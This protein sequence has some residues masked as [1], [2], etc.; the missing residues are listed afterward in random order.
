[1]KV[2]AER[3]DAIFYWGPPAIIIS[4]LYFYLRFGLGIRILPRYYFFVFFLTLL[5]STIYNLAHRLTLP[6]VLIE[7]DKAGIYIYKRRNKPAIT[8]RYEQLWSATALTGEKDFDDLDGPAYGLKR[9]L[10]RGSSE[11]ITGNS[12]FN[13]MTGAL[14]IELP[15]QFI[16][17][18]GV[19]NVQAV[20][21]DLEKL[22][23]DSKK[24]RSGNYG[25]DIVI[26]TR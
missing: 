1:M 7:Y 20:R 18:H 11:S 24:K 25:T 15:D 26:R 5:I 6:K 17:I 2:L 12:S 9:L 8:I 19:K 3:S 23:A 22:I 13:T 14:R 4:I 16:K 21:R 10:L